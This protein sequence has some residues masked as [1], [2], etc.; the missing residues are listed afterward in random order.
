MVILFL[1]FLVRLLIY[2]G[3]RTEWSQNLTRLDDTKFVYQLIITITNFVIYWAFLNQ[4]S[5]NSAIFFVGSEKKPFKCALAMARSVQL[6]RLDMYCVLL[7]C[8]ISAEIRTVD[9]LS[10]LRNF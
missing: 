4:N 1:N 8:P 5:R 2:S 6:L 3:N 7:H 10:D 9:S